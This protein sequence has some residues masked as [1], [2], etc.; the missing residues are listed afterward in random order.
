MLNTFFH[1]CAIALSC[2]RVPLPHSDQA[3]VLY[4]LLSFVLLLF[5]INVMVVTVVGFLSG[6]SVVLAFHLA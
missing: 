2:L 1:R 6:I 5:V 4:L 3:T